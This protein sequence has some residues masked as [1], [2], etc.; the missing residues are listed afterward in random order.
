MHVHDN[1]NN[2]HRALGTIFWLGVLLLSWQAKK[3]R[4]ESPLLQQVGYFWDAT[5]HKKGPHFK[6]MPFD[7][8]FRF[9]G[10]SKVHQNYCKI[11]INATIHWT[12]CPYKHAV[13]PRKKKGKPSW[14]SSKDIIMCLV[15]NERR[16]YALDNKAN[17]LIKTCVAIKIFYW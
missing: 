8:S 16:E 6:K 11:V 15:S 13:R 4:K 2:I 7:I 10:S 14:I 1:N 3:R 17:S 12:L 5:R 9:G